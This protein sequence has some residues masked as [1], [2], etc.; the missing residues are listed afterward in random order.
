MSQQLVYPGKS[1]A[2]AVGGSGQRRQ[3]KALDQIDLQ[4]ELTRAL[5][6]QHGRTAGTVI[7]LHAAL[8]AKAAERHCELI[9][10]GDAMAAGDPRKEMAVSAHIHA[11][12]NA[13]LGVQY[14]FSNSVLG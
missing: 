7:D 2:P 8:G 5:Y 1:Y 4:G 3:Q 11:A 9:D 10:Y 13:M 6:V 14:R 12:G